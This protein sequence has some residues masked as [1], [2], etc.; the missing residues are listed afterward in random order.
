MIEIKSKLTDTEASTYTGEV[1]YQSYVLNDN[2]LEYTFFAE[3]ECKDDE[4]L[5]GTEEAFYDTKCIVK[6]EFLMGVQ[7][8]FNKGHQRYIVDIMDVNGGTFP[9]W[10]KSEEEAIKICNQ[11]KEWLLK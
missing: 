10:C 3:E 4:S 5:T 2:H 7:R 6:K 9:Y 11:I 8:T 1:N